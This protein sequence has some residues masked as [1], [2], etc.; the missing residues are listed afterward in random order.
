M[1]VIFYWISENQTEKYEMGT[2]TLKAFS[3]NIQFKLHFF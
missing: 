2:V 3:Q 1:H